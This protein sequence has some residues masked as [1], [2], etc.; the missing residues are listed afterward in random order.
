MLYCPGPC[1]PRGGNSLEILLALLYPL[2]DH[3]IVHVAHLNQVVCSPQQQLL[4]N[5]YLEIL[6]F[7][8]FVVFV[9]AQ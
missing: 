9:F 2:N 1:S 7:V 3:L 5:K 6:Y 4:K 8:V